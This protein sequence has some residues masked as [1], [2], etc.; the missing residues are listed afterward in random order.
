MFNRVILIGHIGKTPEIRE[1]NERQVANFDLATTKIWT[2][3]A[4]DRQESTEW[5]SCALWRRDL[6]H[7][8]ERAGSGSLLLVE[9]ELSH[10]REE[11]KG[12]LRRWTDVRVLTYRILK[13]QAPEMVPAED[14]PPAGVEAKG[15][16]T[17]Q[18][19]DPA[20]TDLG[21]AGE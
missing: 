6:S 16:A 21:E 2:D 5:H 14:H 20:A 4:G 9:G 18:P 7:F 3:D 19:T 15:D 12:V 17:A 13:S 1:I 11:H 10:R 8:T